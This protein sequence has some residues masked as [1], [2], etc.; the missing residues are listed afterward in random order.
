MH[1]A[2]SEK[3]AVTLNYDDLKGLKTPTKTKLLSVII[4]D[5][6][7]TEGHLKRHDFL[8][9]IKKHFGDQLDIFGRGFNYVNDKWDAIA[10]YKYHVA[11]ENSQYPHYWTEKLADAFLGWS[12]IRF[13][14]DVRM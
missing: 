8:Q 1:Y 2:P 13:I 4:S 14:M 12:H 9:A 7:F 10:D 5:K 11:I 6:S 3:D